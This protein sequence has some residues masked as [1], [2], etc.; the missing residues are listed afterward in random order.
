MSITRNIL[1][2]V[3]KKVDE[4]D[5]DNDKLA[6]PKCFGLGM[7][8]GMVDVSVLMVPIVVGAGVV[9]LIKNHD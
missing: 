4:V 2:W 7:I 5:V 6:L 8:E 3:D 9:Y 1:D